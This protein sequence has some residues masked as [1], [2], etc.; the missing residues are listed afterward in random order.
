MQRLYLFDI[1]KKKRENISDVKRFIDK[2]YYEF[3]TFAV[4]N[5]GIAVRCPQCDGL[6]LVTLAD[7]TFWLRCT[8]CGKRRHKSKYQQQYDVHGQCGQCGR[9]FRVD[10]LDPQDRNFAKLRV[11]CPHCGALAVGTVHTTEKPWWGF[12]EIT[13][14]NEPYFGCSLYYR[15]NFQGKLIWAV[16]REHLQYL[17]DYLAADLRQKPPGFKMTQSD[18]LPAFMKAAKNRSG[19]VKALRKMQEGS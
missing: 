19:I 4:L 8:A 7:D 9:Y 2:P 3:C 6:A 17:I 11:A 13:E 18:H 14:G 5:A 10:I 1:I 16:N 12:E 15:E